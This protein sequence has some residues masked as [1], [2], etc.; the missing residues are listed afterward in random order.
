MENEKEGVLNGIEDEEQKTV[1]YL[2]ILI[3]TFS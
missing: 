1:N 3:I 2:N